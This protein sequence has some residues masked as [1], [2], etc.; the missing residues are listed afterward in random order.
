MR[1]LYLC[2]LWTF[3]AAIHS[4]AVRGEVSVKR[5]LQISIIGGCHE[6]HTE[7]YSEGEGKI[8]PAKALKGSSIG[9]QGPWGTT[10][11]GNLRLDASDLSEDGFLRILQTL[12]ASPPMS[13]YN[14]RALDE[15]DMRS[16]YQYI[17]SL[18]EPGTRAPSF[19]PPGE[20]VRTQYI[21][22]APP[23]LPPA[24]T[25]DLDCGVGEVCGRSEPRSCIPK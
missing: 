6:C 2:F 1:T 22:L 14:L 24:C 25:R 11:P 19:V 12:K 9:W 21:V 3:L 8:D 13:W 15:D 10:Y 23:Q 4:G 16:L 7:G 18:G 20:K 17:R 5:G